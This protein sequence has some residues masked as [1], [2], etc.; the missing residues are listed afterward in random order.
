MFSW[1]FKS[2]K[3]N[4]K[5]LKKKYIKSMAPQDILKI[6]SDL[7]MIQEDAQQFINKK[8]CIDE[9]YQWVNKAFEKQEAFYKN[10]NCLND[11]NNLFNQP[12]NILYFFGNNG[13]GKTTSI[14]NFATVLQQQNKKVLLIAADEFRGG[15]V[16][17]LIDMANMY[18]LP[19]YS[20]FNYTNPVS[21]NQIIFDGIEK[22]AQDYDIILIDTAGRS[23]Q[24][25]SLI[26]SLYKQYQLSFKVLEKME[27]NI[28]SIWVN[29]GNMVNVFQQQSL[30]FNKIPVDYIIITKL[31]KIMV[32]II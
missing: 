23:H 28:Y 12:I 17:Q 9:I 10:Y 11:I 13:I 1:L 15:A 7:N 20:S 8:N 16:Q 18:N 32:I 29:D 26:D 5:L 24:D 14:I 25:V 21:L 31:K 19:V 6:L 27:K 30:F 3:T 4:L 22:H 2:N